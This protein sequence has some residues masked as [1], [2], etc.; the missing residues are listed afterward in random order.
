MPAKIPFFEASESLQQRWRESTAS[1]R[2]TAQV[3]V[4]ALL[5]AIGLFRHYLAPRS[6]PDHTFGSAAATDAPG[7][8]DE[9]I[10]EVAEIF[11][12]PIK[13]CAGSSVSH[14]QLT[15]QGF[16]L[17]RRWMVVRL[18]EGKVEK[19][20]LKEEPRLTLI[21]PSID[22]AH[23][24][25]SIKLTKEGEKVHKGT[26]L[27]ETETVL[28]PT[29][30]ELRKW[31]EVPRVEMYGDLADGRVAALPDSSGRK[32]SPSEWISEFLGYAVL[33][34]HFDTTSR[35]ARAAFPIFKPPTDS[36][37]WSSH[38]RGELY[39]ERGIEFQDEYPL[40]IATQESLS[41]VRNQLT[42]ALSPNGTEGRPIAGIDA[43]KWADSSALSIARFRPNIVLRSSPGEAFAPFSEDSWE[44]I[45]IL[46]N[47]RSRSKAVLQLVARCQRCLLTAVDPI[48]AEKDASVPL[49]LLN[50][51]RM[52][53]KKTAS[54]GGNGR[55]GPCFGMY[56]I[57]LPL[58]TSAYGELS[59]G[60][61]VK[62]RWRPFSTD[63]E[64]DRS[65]LPT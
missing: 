41:L 14:A 38:D 28:R 27:G 39:R 44:R 17:D 63:D 37:S 51:S 50:R 65:H 42:S 2:V 12:Y 30:E 32:L 21:Q 9:T 62:V 61:S 20:S 13:S 36:A 15:Q 34:I 29:A 56:A 18:R 60:D 31:K 48:T 19:M 11:I 1:P 22:E 58:D 59:T 6:S 55:A 40:L 25:L 46:P 5:I 53:V 49:K 4:F 3:Y 23:N 64:P 7:A 47:G 8:K 52:R 33:L 54:E 43:T 35:T 16:D 57:P 10:A 26:K 45:W 24:R